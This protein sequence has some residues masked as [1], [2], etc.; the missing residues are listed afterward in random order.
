MIE[1]ILLILC[2]FIFM[3]HSFFIYIL[4]NKSNTTLY[5]GVTNNL[6]RRVYEHKNK[7]VEGFTKRY[8]IDKLIYFEQT[9]D[10]ETAIEREKQIKNYSRKKKDI[11]IKE[12]NPNWDDLYEKI[13]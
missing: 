5:V 1:Y 11:L 9:A 6:I 7:L 13:T 4:A 12:F 10:V 8:N 3:T 2:Y